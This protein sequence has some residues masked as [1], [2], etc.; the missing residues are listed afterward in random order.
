MNALRKEGFVFGLVWP[1]LNYEAMDRI[2]FEM[3]KPI[4]DESFAQVFVR[5][6]GMIDG[7]DLEAFLRLPSCSIGKVR[8]DPPVVFPDAPPDYEIT[9]VDLDFIRSSNRPQEA[10]ACIRFAA[11]VN[12]GPP[13]WIT[14]YLLDGVVYDGDNCYTEWGRDAATEHITDEVGWKLLPNA[15]NKMCAEIG[16]LHDDGRPCVVIQWF[17]LVGSAFALPERRRVYRFSVDGFGMISEVYVYASEENLAC[18]DLTGRRP[19]LKADL[20]YERIRS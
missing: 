6:D 5:K 3:K 7:V 15:G 11:A 9:A 12:G 10:L 20:P 13:W 8:R 16:Q 17:E 14:K 2:I 18:C 19:A 4:D 1:D